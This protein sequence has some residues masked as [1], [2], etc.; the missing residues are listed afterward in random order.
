VGGETV[1]SARFLTPNARMVTGSDALGWVSEEA[2]SNSDN[3]PLHEYV[4]L[5]DFSGEGWSEVAWNPVL[6]SRTLTSKSTE[7]SSVTYTESSVETLTNGTDTKTV[8][9]TAGQNRASLKGSS[10]ESWTKTATSASNSSS[11]SYGWV[12][13]GDSGTKTDDLAISVSRSISTSESKNANGFIVGTASATF[14]MSYDEA[15][16]RGSRHRRRWAK[17]GVGQSRQR[18][19]SRGAGSTGPALAT[20]P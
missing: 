13:S 8:A 5:G 10:T 17:G 7:G 19:N 1:S 15:A 3:Y 12:Y 18:F 11:T 9:F 14:N 16:G 20:V 2:S 4:R 6:P